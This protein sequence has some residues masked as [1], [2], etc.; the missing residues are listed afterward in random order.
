MRTARLALLASAAV[1]TILLAGCSG[2]GAG[3]SGAP[4]STASRD[5]LTGT[6]TVLAAASLTEVYGELASQF[7]KLHPG[8]TITE[9]FGGSSALATQIVQGAPADLF[10]TANQ[11]TMK[12]V[13]DAGLTDGIPIVY[14]SNV[15]T[16]IVPSG[17]PANVTSLADLAKPSVKVALCDKTV[18]CGSAAVTLLADENL[19]VTPVTLEQDVKSVLTK[20]ELDEVDAGLVYVT[21]AVSAGSTVKRIAVPD[22]ANVVN[23]YPIALLRSST[24]TAAATAFEHFILSTT[25]LLA[26]KRAGFG[27]P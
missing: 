13:T 23:R 6:V 11:A 1:V 10:A 3:G 9:S 8:V 2:T 19:K 25:G 4:M 17:N 12:T 26:L 18:P 15:L 16:L 27:T 14:A 20:V 24:N 22:A 7:E 5:T 21:D